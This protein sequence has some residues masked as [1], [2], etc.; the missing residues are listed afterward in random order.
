MAVHYRILTAD[1]VLAFRALRLEALERHP[2]A[3][4][5]SAAGF[6]AQPVEETARFMS[7]RNE[8]P[9]QFV[10]GAFDENVLVGLAGFYRFKKRKIRHR[11]G[12]WTVYVRT[13]YR[14]HNV[15]R[16]LMERII[17]RARRIEGLEHLEL[18]V[19]TT[20][21]PAVRLYESLGFLTYG[22]EPRA[23]KI[24]DRYV[25]IHLM[26]LPLHQD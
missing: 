12:I 3:F 4:G 11:G 15:G 8:Y 21:G 16:Q 22:T 1:D 2:D 20:G 24:S 26:W 10:E 23:M 25:D 9:E 6:E 5:E 13:E 7:P 18:G 14:A 19:A 17:T